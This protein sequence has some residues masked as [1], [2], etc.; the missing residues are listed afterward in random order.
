MPLPDNM[1]T[2]LEAAL[3]ADGLLKKELAEEI[4]AQLNS[5]RPVNWN[6]LMSKELEPEKEGTD[7]A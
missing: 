5:Q 3:T 4:T 7:E 2:S 6:L 1:S